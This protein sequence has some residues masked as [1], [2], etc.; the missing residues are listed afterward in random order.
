MAE[1]GSSQDSLILANEI[2]FAEDQGKNKSK[3]ERSDRK[4]GEHKVESFLPQVT[5]F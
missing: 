3:D 2:V 4:R 5:Q 1:P